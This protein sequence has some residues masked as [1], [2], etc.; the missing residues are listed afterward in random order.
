MEKR[1]EIPESECLTCHYRMDSTF[2]TQGD[3]K[4][5]KDDLSVCLKCGTV[6]KFDDSY[7]LV[8]LT[9]E[10]LRELE[11]KWPDTYRELRRVQRAINS[12]IKEN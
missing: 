2:C 8:A 1:N 7:N 10:E 9:E 3:H 4:A 12:M 11:E 6:T 5:A